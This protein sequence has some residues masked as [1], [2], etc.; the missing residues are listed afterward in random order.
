LRIALLKILNERVYDAGDGVARRVPLKL[1]VAASNEWAAPETGRELA[2]L[3]DRF[4]LRKSVRPIRSRIGRERLLWTADHTPRLSTTISPTEVEDARRSAQS[5]PWSNEAREALEAVLAELVRD[6]IC[7]G[8]RRQFKTVGVVRA[9][10]FL[11][12]AERVEPEH[13]EVA[14]HTLWDVADEQ[15]AKVAQVIARIANPTGMRVTQLLLEV[16]SVLTATDVRNLAEAAK[17]A[18]KLAEIDKQL[19]ALSGNGRVEKARLYL[20]EQLK[21]LKLASIEAI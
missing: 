17:A 2:A 8:D 9:F 13:L 4:V 11:T 1:C 18:A 10:A 15:P 12:G 14:Q 16:E 21:K 7:P 19:S 3:S 5:L 20:K 6:G